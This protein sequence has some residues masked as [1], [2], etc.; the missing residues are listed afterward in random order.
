MNFRAKIVKVKTF[1]AKLLK[2]MVYGVG[3]KAILHYIYEEYTKM[4]LKNNSISRNISGNAH[5]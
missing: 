2:F 3:F 5:L 1:T 4:I